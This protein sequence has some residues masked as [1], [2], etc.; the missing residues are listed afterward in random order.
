MFGCDGKTSLLH[1]SERSKIDIV[2]LFNAAKKMEE[3]KILK[4]VFSI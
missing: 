2:T 1:L 4:E 3:K